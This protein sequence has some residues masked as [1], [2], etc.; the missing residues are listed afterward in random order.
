[1]NLVNLTPHVITIYGPAGDYA[2]AGEIILASI[3]PSGTVARV[4]TER[5]QVGSID[6]GGQAVP[7]NR[8]VFGAAEG[9]PRYKLHCGAEACRLDAALSGRPCDHAPQYIVSAVVAQAVAERTARDDILTPDDAVRDGA[10]RV[11]GCR[12]F[13]RVG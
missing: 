1:M 13:A 2:P 8:T 7:I 6:I 3:P 5:E 11:I 9:L 12:A 4:A 10:G